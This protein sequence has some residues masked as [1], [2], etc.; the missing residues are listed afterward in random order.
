M[1]RRCASR[2]QHHALSFVL[3]LLSTLLLSAAAQNLQAQDD[4]D[5][6]N[7]ATGVPATTAPAAEGSD[8]GGGTTVGMVLIFFLTYGLAIAGG[9]FGIKGARKMGYCIPKTKTE[10]LKEGFLGGT[11]K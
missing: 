5:A 7:N 6:D 11:A 9:I 2:G 4:F 1:T 3:L 8:D 10:K